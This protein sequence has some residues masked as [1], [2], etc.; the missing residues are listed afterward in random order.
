MRCK[1]SIGA[2]LEVVINYLRVDRLL[3]YWVELDG[4][5][6]L[7]QDSSWL[8]TVEPISEFYE[9]YERLD[10]YHKGRVRYFV[11]CLRAGQTLDPIVI[12]NVCHGMCVYPIPKFL[13]GNHRFMAH[14]L[15]GRTTIPASYGG[16]VDLLRY[17]EGKRRQCPS[18]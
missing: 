16:R 6:G 13:D 10:A 11:D 4:A 3:K 5:E 12:D 2:P 17:L 8:G 15:T 9:E 18:E 14:V 7:L 1:V